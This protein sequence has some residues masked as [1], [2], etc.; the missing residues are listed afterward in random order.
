MA[1]AHVSGL[2][3]FLYSYYTSF[4]YSQIRSTI[5]RYGDVL[6]TLSGLIQ[7][8]G[9]VNAYRA[10]SSLLTPSELILNAQSSSQ[11]ALIWI[12]NATGE[13]GYKIERKT[14]SGSFTQITTVSANTT[15]YTNSSLT[16]GTT[17]SYR[18]RA[19]NNIGDSFYSNE[20]SAT[21]P[22]PINPPT[23][24]TATAL[25]GSQV[26][27]AWTENSQSEE[28][29]KIERKV[30]PGDFAQIAVVGPNTTT[31][32][33]SSGLSPSTT[34]YYRVRSFNAAS[35][36]SPYSNEAS[37]TTLSTTGES[38][39]GGGGGGCS[40]GARQNT[41]TAVADFAVM[42]I[43]LLFVVVMKFRRRV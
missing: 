39:G 22:I 24:L 8:G 28:G 35:G 5:F 1:T 43:P 21:T 29:F 16:D 14:G 10:L 2:A 23:G 12:D 7:T 40:I 34:Y 26:S 15:S 11:I 17:Y 30:V 36:N 37:V 4:N 6:Q 33:D 20:A 38:S 25:S 42:L 9:R 18:V 3:G 31:Y 32:S 19:F 41:P 13:D 27:L